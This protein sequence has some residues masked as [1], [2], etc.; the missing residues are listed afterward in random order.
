MATRA[1]LTEERGEEEEEKRLQQTSHSRVQHNSS[2]ETE[3][4]LTAATLQGWREK[5]Y[6]I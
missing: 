5:G 2:M 6:L 4:F 1:A 3:T